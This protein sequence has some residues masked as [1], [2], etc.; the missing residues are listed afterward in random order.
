MMTKLRQSTGMIMWF[1]IAAFVGLIVV[2]WGAD[3]SGTSGAR[4]TDAVGSI[5]G[6]EIP[7][8]QFQAALRNSARQRREAG[9]DDGQLVREV[10]DSIVS[11]VLIRQQIESMGIQVSDEELA[12]FTRLSPPP[13]VQQ[14][15]SFQNEEGEFDQAIYQQFLSNPN[16]HTDES[17]RAFILQV[18]GMIHSQLLNQ[19]LQ[20]LL[21]ETVRITPQEL[22]QYYL[23]QNEKV[24]VDYVYVAAT[25][26]DESAVNLTEGGIQAQYD[27]M[28]PE[29]QH[30]EQV[31]VSYVMFPR[32]PSAADS[33]AIE[34][35]AHRLR[36]E[37]VDAGADFADMAVAV[38][39]DEVSAA[40]G[41]VLGDFGRGSM[42][43]EF[44]A[45][46]FA[47][48]PGEV[49][50]PVRTTFGWHLILVEEKLS[51]D[52]ES[53][54]E[55]VRARHI[56]LKFRPSPET[57]EEALEKAESYRQLAA[58]RGLS[59]AAAIEG[60]EVRDPSW[61]GKGGDLGGLG[62]GTQWIASRFF[63]S[64]IGEISPVGSTDA[65]YFVASLEDRRPQGV[66][67]LEEARRQVE[68]ALRATTRAEIASGRLEAVRQAV[69]G[70]QDFSAAASDAELEVR[71]GG[72]FSRTDFVPGAGRGSRFIG[73]AFE[74][75]VG[76]ISDVV[77]QNNGAYLL[78][79]T[80]RAPIDEAAFAEA[81]ATVESQLL[82]ARQTEGLQTWFAQIFNN[83]D[84]QDH[85]HLFYSF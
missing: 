9:R 67:P 81:R 62:V 3:F 69:A 37:I 78:R 14:L 56:L 54:E 44:E 53:P 51:P 79:L 20:S 64:E 70:G 26:V 30:P 25:T 72:P 47:L 2:E 65:G 76:Q 46:A 60:F 27:R 1:V 50:Q 6:V 61:I 49:S 38:S 22:R 57:E 33:A 15:P 11:Q 85:R 52:D 84:I 18:E 59:A 31:R 35:E 63:E 32:L 71:T 24:T 45:A 23:D 12:Y 13:E 74:L 41:G 40:N 39:E 4:S 55:R 34:E 43:P 8:R 83:A 10:W 28:E 66:V 16:T 82:Q 73:V 77:V 80:E 5:N 29:L 42:V 68:Y 21:L 75:S 17:N 48:V 58:E 19:R 7:L 36:R